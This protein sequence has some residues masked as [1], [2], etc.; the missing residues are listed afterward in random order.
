MNTL[1]WHTI[2]SL[3]LGAA[4]VAPWSTLGAALLLGGT[5]YL[6]LQA[7]YRAWRGGSLPGRHGTETYW[8]G[9]RIDLPPRAN[10]TK[11]V[12]LQTILYLALGTAL[13]GIA[14]CMLLAVASGG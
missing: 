12:P 11:T 2:V 8:R 7:G 3:L 9:R 14:L 6:V 10:G 5:A 1:N 13:A 4:V